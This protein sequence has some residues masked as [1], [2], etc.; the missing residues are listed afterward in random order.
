MPIGGGGLAAGIAIYSKFL[1]PDVKSSASSR[2][3]RKHAGRP[4]AGKR[5]VLDGWDFSRTVRRSSRWVKKHSG[6]AVSIS[7]A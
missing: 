1:R 6:F 3:T 7:T 4:Q 2:K 5:V